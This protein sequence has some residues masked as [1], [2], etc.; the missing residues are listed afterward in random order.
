MDDKSGEEEAQ[1]PSVTKTDYAPAMTNS[2][3][4]E[5]H[6]GVSDNLASSFPVGEAT[7]LGGTYGNN[8]LPSNVMMAE[9]ANSLENKYVNNELPSNPL[10]H[11][12]DYGGVRVYV[13]ARCPIC[14]ND[15]NTI[16]AL[17]CGHFICE[18]DY[19]WL[20]GYLASD[21]DKLKGIRRAQCCH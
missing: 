11:L 18:E 20:G 12:R 9:K 7:S 4:T 14:L 3:V 19:M 8:E 6:A 5:K 10:T 2:T 21:K 13:P 17:R 1:L 16:V 15:R